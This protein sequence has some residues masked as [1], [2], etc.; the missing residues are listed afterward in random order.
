MAGDVQFGL[1]L[2]NR[3]V[4]FGTP[5]EDL[6]ETA[7]QAEQ[8]GMIDSVWV[9]DNMLSKP[10][11][12]AVVTLTAIAAQTKRIKLGTICMASFP[13]RNPILFA[14]QWASLDM[15]SNGRTFLTVCIGTEASRGPQFAAELTAMGIPSNE[16][17]GRMEEGIE[18]LRRFWTESSV[19][20]NGTY[21][22][23]EDVDVLPKPVQSPTPICIAV[24]PPPTASAEVEERALRRVARL[25]DGWQTDSTPPKKF[26]SRWSRIMEYAEEYGRANEV[27]HSMLHLM[28][29][30]Q[31][32]A[33]AA[34]QEGMEFFDHYYGKGA[35][36]DAMFE[37]WV[38]YGPPEQV[39]E[40]INEYVE[41]GCNMP[42]LRFISPD[43]AGQFERCVSDVLPQFKQSIVGG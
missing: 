42:V 30:I 4:L 25:G 29:N 43:Q 24:N 40:K 34:R 36:P 33:E 1:S 41:A 38:A 11:L 19:T 31:D 8:S 28:V 39:A 27:K 9:G 7:V 37:E 20:Y 17:V 23:Y 3:A 18:L 22:Q 14:I 35:I 6:L 26:G 10:R 12:E 16:R 5:V 15:I 2:P 13:T 21:Y 32:S